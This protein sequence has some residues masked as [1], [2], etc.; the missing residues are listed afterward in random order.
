[1]SSPDPVPAYFS[2]RYIAWFIWTN[3]ITGLALIQA[4]LAGLMMD[5]ELFSHQTFRGIVLGNAI[6]T[7][8][9]AQVKRNTP[10]G[11]APTKTP[12]Q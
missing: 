3:L 7:I 2:F 11:P 4:V 8:V 12:L 1:M 5:Q 6:L 9:I 10:P